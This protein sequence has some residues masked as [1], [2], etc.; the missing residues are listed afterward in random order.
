MKA[1]WIGL[2]LLVGVIL[3]SCL[4]ANTSNASQPSGLHFIE[5]DSSLPEPIRKLT[6]TWTGKFDTPVPWEGTLY[7][8]RVGLDS[9]QVTV[10]WDNFPHGNALAIM[11]GCHCTPGF[12]NIEDAKV[13]FNDNQSTLTFRRPATKSDA[14]DPS[15]L[16][17]SGGSNLYT[18]T[19]HPAEP[20][21]LNVVFTNQFHSLHAVFRRVSVKPE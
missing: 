11:K 7:I 1:K 12:W 14:A 8:V 20:D 4:E 21:V 10:S 16:H 15:S 18:A 17:H 6:G 2:A 3:L 5:P 19:Y 13:T 9:A